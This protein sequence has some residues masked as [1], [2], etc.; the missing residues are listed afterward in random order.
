MKQVVSLIQQYIRS[1]SYSVYDMCNHVGFW[2][3]LLLRYSA[4]N[5]QLCV[6]VVVGNPYA[7][8]TPK[9]EEALSLLTEEIRKEIDQ[10]MREVLEALQPVVDVI[11][12]FNYQMYA[13]G[14]FRNS[15][16]NECNSFIYLFIHYVYEWMMDD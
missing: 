3:S 16:R 11:A 7:K 8:S 2:R 4:R 12:S 6:L 14:L 5:N 10:V 13:I 15:N 9:A 1:T